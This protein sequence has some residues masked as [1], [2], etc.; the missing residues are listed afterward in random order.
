M[1]FFKKIFGY[2]P[3]V[4]VKKVKKI[5]VKLNEDIDEFKSIDPFDKDKYIEET[6]EKIFHSIRVDEWPFIFSYGEITFQKD[7]VELKL[8]FSSYKKFIIK[9]IILSSG[10]ET[11]YYKSDLDFDIY[12]FFYDI[13]SK[14]VEERNGRLKKSIDQ[15]LEKINRV[16]G[17]DTIRDSKIDLILKR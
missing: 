5:K 7:S 11:Y 12:K 14:S 2:K 13:Y 4:E 17:R 16:I 3:N 9:R 6:F 1:S 8:E 10:Y 15:N